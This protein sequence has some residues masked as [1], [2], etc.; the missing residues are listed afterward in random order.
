MADGYRIY[1]SELSPYSVKVRSWFRYKGV[2]HEWIARGPQHEE[3]FRRLAKLPLI[4]LVVTPT[5]E[6]LQDSTPLIETLEK[7]LPELSIHPYDAVARFV[8]FLLEE[9]ADE[10]GNKWMF[11]YRW[12]Y[13]ADQDSA[14]ERLA[15]SR[16]GVLGE[17][18]P[19][20]AA[21]VK[22]RMIGRLSF[23]GS[24]AATGP[25]IEHSFGRVLK[26]L[27]RHLAD[28]AYVF[29]GAPGLGDFGLWG[30]LYECWTDPTPGAKI[31]QEAPR[32][33][34]WI[35]RMLA[36]VKRG[37]FEPWAWL[38]PT[39]MP[40][41]KEE[42]AGRFLPWS[43]ANAR[44]LAEGAQELLAEIDGKAFIQQPQKYHARSLQALK[45]RYAALPE[46]ER[47]AVDAALAPSGCLRYLREAKA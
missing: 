8:S 43:A 29:G 31:R 25:I 44:A 6:A 42:V 13:P 22:E 1:G 28:R 47:A 38:A 33:A 15:A 16:F 30:Q 2:D 21:K 9:Y 32:V 19:A 11:H 3:E 26:L 5:G 23:V 45:A 14:A 17:G 7:R 18:L 27:E 12:S 35:E 34:A 24:S 40:L 39:L 20:A 46:N 4:P 36:P 41:L 37:P 10:W